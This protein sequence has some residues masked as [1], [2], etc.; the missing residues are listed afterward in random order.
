[1][2]E[3]SRYPFLDPDYSYDLNA[4]T[5]EN[6]SDVSPSD[7]FDSTSVVTHYDVPLEGS[8]TDDEVTMVQSISDHSLTP[9]DKVD[10]EQCADSTES[11]PHDEEAETNAMI[12]K[13]IIYAVM[14]MY[15]CSLS[16]AQAS[17]Q[18]SQ[19]GNTLNFV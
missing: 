8:T 18:V 4:T 1:V 2:L 9:A 15:L 17:K 7:V 12:S 11:I 14:L 6:S 3:I 16:S 5:D 10:L 13:C 19:S